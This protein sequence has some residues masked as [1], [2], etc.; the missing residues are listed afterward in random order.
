MYKGTNKITNKSLGFKLTNSTS[1][2][3]SVISSGYIQKT[4]KGNLHVRGNHGIPPRELHGKTLEDS[5]RLHR[6]EARGTAMWGRP[7]PHAGRPAPWPTC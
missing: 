2:G 5:R 6:G 3:E 1:F 4:V 7:A